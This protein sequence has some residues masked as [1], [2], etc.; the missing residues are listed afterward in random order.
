MRFLPG[1]FA[2]L[3]VQHGRAGGLCAGILGEN[4]II[5][6]AITANVLEFAIV[7]MTTLGVCIGCVLAIIAYV[8]AKRLM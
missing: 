2:W 8:K 4:L 6:P 3:R 5:P 7:N 1:L